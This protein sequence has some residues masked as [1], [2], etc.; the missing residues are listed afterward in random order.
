MQFHNMPFRN[1]RSWVLPIV[2]TVVGISC[3]ATHCSDPSTMM[4]E[5][6][7]A[8][9]KP[10]VVIDTV[11]PTGPD[12]APPATGTDDPPPPTSPPA[13][14]PNTDI[15]TDTRSTEEPGKPITEPPTPTI[16]SPPSVPQTQLKP[17]ARWSVVPF[18]RINPGETFNAS[19]VAFS[20]YGIAAVRF[21]ISGPGYN[22][23]ATIDVT[24][25]RYNQQTS[26]YDYWTPISASQFSSD[27]VVTIE[28]EIFGNDGGYRNPST[29]GADLGLAPLTLVMNATGSRPQVQAWVQA[30]GNDNNGLINSPDRPFGTIGRAADA[31]RAYRAAN[32]FG[33]NGDGGIVRLLP[34]NHTCNTGGI[35]DAIACNNEWLTI[36][37]AASGNVSNT[38]LLIG[39]MVP[40]RKLRVRDIT[41]KG[42]GNLRMPYNE[43][44]Q[45]QL[46]IDRCALI[47]DGRTSPNPHPLAIEH[48]R[49]YYTDSSITQ[50]QQATSG[51]FFCRGLKITNLSDDAFQNVPLVLNCVVDDVDP[52]NTG[53]H[54]DVWQHG[55][56]DDQNRMDD[57]VIVYNLVATNLKYQSIFIRGNITRPPS[58]AQGMAFVNVYTEMLPNSAGY[59]GWG[60]WVDHLLWWHCSFAGKGMG[61]MSDTYGDGKKYPCRVRNFSVKGCDFAFF[62]DGN[63]DIDWN[64]FESNHFVDGNVIKGRDV[65]TGKNMLDSSGVPIAGSPLI[66]RMTPVV[67]VDARNKART[68]RADVGA[69]Q[70]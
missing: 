13:T 2:A 22:G 66:G 33:N 25:M 10:N 55:W 37:T 34:G 70:R 28:V 14:E 52:L 1:M 65:T 36:T 60:R 68:D 21:H 30:G 63:S 47:G 64:S 15:D 46:W 41:I 32:G 26:L 7:D 58:M 51:A 39:D 45:G 18:Q 49:L 12:L 8:S 24:Q 40:T 4:P 16:P 48:G 57:N 31:I 23:P 20:K 29:D 3:L 42:S 27:G 5:E 19:V 56:G 35:R 6:S 69:F 11:P 9:S 50:V 53:N 67:P 43:R 61:F 62:G 54:A 44:M 59:G 38:T 17:I